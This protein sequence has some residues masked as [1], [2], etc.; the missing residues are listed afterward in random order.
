LS[1]TLLL[2]GVSAAALEHSQ[3]AVQIETTVTIGTM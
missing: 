2:Q 1:G 3:A